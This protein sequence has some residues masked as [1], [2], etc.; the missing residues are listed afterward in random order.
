MNVRGHYVKSRFECFVTAHKFACF[1]FQN[2]YILRHRFQKDAR[3]MRNEPAPLKYFWK[4]Q[5]M[6]KI[7]YYGIMR[8]PNSFQK[9]HKYN[10][11]LLGLKYCI[12]ITILFFVCITFEDKRELEGI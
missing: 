2:F 1:E 12:R 6:S 10:A 4:L 3:F 9:K 5:G 11:F 8:Q 7:Q